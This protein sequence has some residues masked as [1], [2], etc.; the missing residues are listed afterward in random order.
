MDGK[1]NV[2]HDGSPLCDS[3]PTELHSRSGEVMEEQGMFQTDCS[4]NN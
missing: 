2:N 4:K 3:N 1:A